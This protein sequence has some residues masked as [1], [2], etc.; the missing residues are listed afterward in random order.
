MF[1]FLSS[2]AKSTLMQTFNP[3]DLL[4]AKAKDAGVTMS[5]ICE[6]AGVAQSTP[7]R[8]KADPDSATL[9]TIKKLDEALSRIIAARQRAA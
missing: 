3:I 6:E 9:G 1:A 4:T 2:Y 8:W 5:A 7:S